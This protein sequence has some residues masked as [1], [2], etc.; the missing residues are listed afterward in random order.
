MRCNITA[1]QH[2]YH[3]YLLLKYLEK[4]LA[5]FYK[6]NPH[7]AVIHQRL[8]N[9]FLL[10]CTPKKLFGNLRSFVPVSLLYV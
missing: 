5:V 7:P 4:H 2:I 10:P 3:K 9:R 6:C 1:T 8:G